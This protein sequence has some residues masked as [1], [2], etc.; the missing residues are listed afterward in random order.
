M[1]R[2][3]FLRWKSGFRG[4]FGNVELETLNDDC[5]ATGLGLRWTVIRKPDSID[6]PYVAAV[7]KVNPPDGTQADTP[8]SKATEE[9]T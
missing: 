9:E 3:R 5:K 8:N 4:R 7:A 1:A 2:R 6:V